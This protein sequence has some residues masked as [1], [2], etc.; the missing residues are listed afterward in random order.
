MVPA[1]PTPDRT[2]R[3]E[4]QRRA[5]VRWLG[6]P[7]VLAVLG[8]G[9]IAFWPASEEEIQIEALASTDLD[10]VRRAADNLAALGSTTAVGSLSEARGR[11]MERMSGEGS[12]DF[13]VFRHLSFDLMIRRISDRRQ[14]SDARRLWRALGAVTR[15][16]A[17]LDP[18]AAEARRAQRDEWAGEWEEETEEELEDALETEQMP[19]MD[20]DEEREA[21]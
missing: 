4:T 5:A 8:I 11:L 3:R 9:T 18:Q 20:M 21:R 7:I 12:R 14:S 15:A 2:E 1:D 10:D 13:K 16:I 6:A 17:V 19:V